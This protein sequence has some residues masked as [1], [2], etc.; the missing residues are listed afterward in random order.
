[1]NHTPLSSKGFPQQRFPLPYVIVTVA[2]V[3]GI[4]IALAA[5]Q[6]N[7]SSILGLAAQKA[8]TPVV[9]YGFDEVTG[10]TA[11]DKTNNANHAT[12]AA[13]TATPARQTTEYCIYGRCLYFDGSNDYASRTY[14]SDTELDPGS[15]SVS[16]SLWFN[17]VSSI[18]GTD[19]IL[20]RADGLNGVGYKIYMKSTGH[21]C[22]GFDTSAGTFPS[23]ELCTTNT[24]A[25]SKWTHFEAVKNGTTSLEIYINGQLDTQDTSITSGSISGS[26]TPVYIGIDADGT[27]NPWHGYIDE[28]KITANA[29]NANQVYLNY[30]S[31]GTTT[32]V[33]VKAGDETV[34]TLPSDGLV[35]WWKH[36]ETGGGSRTDSGGNNNLLS[37][38]NIVGSEPGVYNNTT[39]IEGSSS[40]NLYIADASQNGLQLGNTFT[41]S[42]WI[43]F[44]TLGTTSTSE[45]P[46]VSKGNFTTS[47]MSYALVQRG[48]SG[49]TSFRGYISSSGTSYD[50]TH[51]AT[52]TLT[53]NTWYYL[54][55][56]YDGTTSRIYV[57]GVE[58]SNSAYSGTPFNDAQNFYLGHTKDQY[59][60]ADLDETRI[61]SKAL[62]AVEVTDLYNWNPSILAYWNFDDGT[63]LTLYDQSG[64][65]Y[66]GTLAND[67]TAP[68]WSTGQYGGSLDFDGTDDVVTVADTAA[69]QISGAMTV[70]AWVYQD[71]ANNGRIIAKQGGTG[72]RAFTLNTESTTTNYAFS[73]ASNNST[74]F[75]VTSNTNII[76][77][78]WVHVAG[79]YIPGQAL[80]IYIN[81]VL[82]NENTT[83]VPSSQYN[84]NSLPVLF[85]QRG[86]CS[87][88]DWDGKIDEVRLYAYARSSDQIQEDYLATLPSVNG[89]YTAG[90]PKEALVGHWKFDEGNGTT[91][92]NSSKTGSLLNGT[93]SNF[94]SPFTSTSGWSSNG[95]IGKALNFDGSDDSI[96][97]GSDLSIDNLNTISVCSWIYP[98]T[99][100]ESNLGRIF[101]KGSTTTYKEFRFDTGATNALAFTV[102]RATTNA[103]SITAANPVTMNTWSRVCGVYTNGDGGPRIY[104]NGN[105]VSSYTSRSDGT[106]SFTNDASE[107]LY[108]G[109][110]SD[111][112]RTFDG[113]IDELRVYN[114]ALDAQQ[115]KNDFNE[116]KALVWGGLGTV[117]GS[118]APSFENAR[119]YC[120]P[121]DGTTCTPPLAEWKLD[122]NTGTTAADSSGNANTG[123]L[124][125]TTWTRGKKGAAAQFDGVNDYIS[126]TGSGLDISGAITIET[127]F[128]FSADPNGTN[129]WGN[130]DGTGCN[131]QYALWFDSSTTLQYY[132]AAA[133]A[134]DTYDISYT[135]SQNTWYTVT[136]TDNGSGTVTAYIN[137]VPVAVTGGLTNGKGTPG[138]FS[139]GRPG[140]Y[141]GQYFPGAI[142]MVRIFNYVRSPAQVDWSYNKGAPVGWWKLDE[143]TGTT[144][145]DSSG[146]GNNG[147][148]T[149]GASGQTTAGDCNTNAST[150]WYNGRSGKFNSGS[151][152]FDGVSDYVTISGTTFEGFTTTS[153][154]TLAAWIKSDAAG[155]ANN[156]AIL[157]RY[158]AGQDVYSLDIVN[159]VLSF[160]TNGTVRASGTTNLNSSGATWYHVTVAWDR[161]VS[162]TIRLYVNGVPDGTGT[163]SSAYTNYNQPIVIGS[164]NGNGNY[165]DGQIDDVQVFDYAL[166]E[167]QIKTLVN[168]RSA[169]RFGEQ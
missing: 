9:Y 72:S 27:S 112:A 137:G 123:T 117:S 92:N 143:C 82:D 160:S 91:A 64:N 37:D 139:I 67:S 131:N 164:N 42:T 52:Y 168:Q 134:Y 132:T 109:N 129:L 8:P 87:N 28:V 24:Y 103:E 155:S 161:D 35:S 16:I 97:A 23:D 25:N 4:G 46:I 69:L 66:N 148:L 58:V 104:I 78:R 79:V 29:N 156:R 70:T 18:S 31:R 136:I 90:F 62:N 101:H 32:G 1:M 38:T 118:S 81:G 57:N 17:H 110:R 125:G 114:I 22:I 88:C 56:T 3:S 85:G 47:D 6:F 61:Y 45:Q 153:R 151:L 127:T 150:A 145:N 96:N 133:C 49:N 120:V 34:T 130:D 68:A 11:Y 2:L 115:I 54:T 83:S 55:W 140:S 51:T 111:G 165:F 19:T 144:L 106:G 13:S 30:R 77:G 149:L 121:G 99:S 157:T 166:T 59:L 98:R 21:V 135:F 20:S 119:E 93:M 71:T 126:T 95:K 7:R 113:L 159:G 76:T 86:G 15:D 154:L 5:A 74:M 138:N 89:S 12:L 43:R 116:A 63:G 94:S 39:D 146:N 142:D 36:D 158:T 147:S 48:N 65:G 53:T 163:L 162:S 107:S 44:E 152:N 102:A 128:L 108:I 75:D 167:T 122:E 26:S 84:T 124:N 105:E 73:I 10:T 33:G 50:L 100:G 60:D 14:S 169:I 41:I 40:E 141:N 80:R